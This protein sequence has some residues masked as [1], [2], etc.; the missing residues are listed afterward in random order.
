MTVAELRPE[1][2][3]TVGRPLEWLEAEILTLSGHL[4]AATCRFLILIAEYDRRG[5]WGTWECTSA[6]QWLGWKCGMSRR[7]AQEHVRVARALEEL[8]VMTAAFAAG[9][10]SYSKVRAMTRVAT[11]KSE[12]DLVAVA[13]HGTASHVDRIV[14][15]FCTVKRNVDP[16]RGRM[17][18][19][20]RGIWCHTAEDGTGTLTVRGDP[21]AIAAILQTIDSAADRA[22][23]AGRR[24]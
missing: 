20:R 12:S 6:A 13:L 14:A 5:G 21:A 17:Q 19:R 24:A 16:E 3:V 15:G 10:L 8:P 23:E 7:T 22:P 9:Q 11:P 2:D 4:A 18:L 1:V